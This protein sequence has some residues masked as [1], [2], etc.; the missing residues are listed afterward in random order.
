ME[1]WINETCH[2]TAHTLQWEKATLVEAH[3]NS[4]HP[5]VEY[6]SGL[7]WDGTPRLDTWQ[8]V[9]LGAA[10]TPL[11]SEVGKNFFIA[12]CAR[13]M[14]PGCKHDTML[15]WES[16]EQGIGKSTAVAIIGG[17][18]AADFKIDPQHYKDT[19][20]D[21][22]GAWICEI[23]EMEV[24]RRA[25]VQALKAFLSR[26]TDRVRLSYARRT[27]N[28]PRQSVFV[29]RLMLR[30]E[31]QTILEIRAETDASIRSLLLESNLM[32]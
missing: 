4:F 7:T 8:H 13:V 30:R 23:A 28:L 32:S 3:N 19:V 22:Q 31:L 11:N 6:L 16:E 21:M 15:V 17:P 18:F 2:Y 12:A 29:E 24:A 20:H 5:V 25:D 14:Q 26:T 1:A 9:Y 10:N 27:T